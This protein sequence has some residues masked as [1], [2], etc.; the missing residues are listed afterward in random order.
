MAVMSS[1]NWIGTVPS[2][3]NNELLNNVLRGEWG[4][5]GMVETDYDGSYGYMITDHCIRNGNDF[6]L[7]AYDMESNHLTDKTSATSVIAMRQAAKNIMYTV[8]NSRAYDV[9]NLQTGLMPWQI[10]MIVI[11][12]ILVAGVIVLEVITIKKYRERKVNYIEV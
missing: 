10:T 6:C 1:F 7:V 3:A 5:V 9:E 12:V 4:F 2:C 11:D 8:V